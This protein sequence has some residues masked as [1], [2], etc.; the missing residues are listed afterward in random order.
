MKDRSAFTF[1]RFTPEA[2]KVLGLAQEEALRLQHNYIGT[3]HLLAGLLREDKSTAAVVLKQLG[4][5]LET[6]R[7]AVE[8]VV[9]RSVHVVFGQISLNAEARRTI[10]LAVNEVLRLNHERLG[11]EHILL[12]L[13]ATKE[14]IAVG[15]L[16]SLAIEPAMVR[17]KTLQAIEHL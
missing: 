13:V 17:E 11:T 1:N 2:K 4:V 5:E 15:I 3:E 12:G 9:G 8:F 7:T 14:S 16:S 10:E 6:V